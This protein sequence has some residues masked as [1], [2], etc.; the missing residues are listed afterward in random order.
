LERVG[1][2]QLAGQTIIVRQ[3]GSVAPNAPNISGVLDAT[4]AAP[5]LV[6]GAWMSIF[7]TNLASSSRQWN[8][9]DFSGNR[10]PTRLDDVTVLVNGFLAHVAFISPTQINFLAPD[11]PGVGPV[12]IRVSNSLGASRPFRLNK[13]AVA[14]N[15]FSFSASNLRIASAVFA[16]GSRLAP[17]GLFP[18]TQYRPARRG[19]VISFFATGCGSTIPGTPTELIVANPA[20]LS[21]P[22]EVWS[23]SV[24]FTVLYAGIVSPGLCQIN[25]VVPQGISS[26]NMPVFLRVGNANSS[27][28]VVVPVL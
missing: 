11:F 14:P 25:A 15:L 10:L 2:I 20:P 16:D 8:G 18:G 27:G 21:R 19:E 23:G 7:G 28:T 3:S 13:E 1:T 17:A 12:E 5:V 6:S 24:N 9:T 22:V 26:G 4:G